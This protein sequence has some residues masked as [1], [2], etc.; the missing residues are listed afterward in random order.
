VLVQVCAGVAM[1]AVAGSF[2]VTLPRMKTS[3]AV[4]EVFTF[5]L[6]FLHG[7]E[8]AVLAAAAEA[9]AALCCTSN[10]WTSRIAGR[11]LRPSP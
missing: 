10:R 2:P 3:F 8:P 7:V 5:L 6:L 11:P 9:A 1:A 4:G